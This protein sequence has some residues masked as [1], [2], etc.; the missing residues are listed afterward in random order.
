MSCDLL[1]GRVADYSAKLPAS[2]LSICP[3]ERGPLL[4]QPGRYLDLGFC[5]C[6]N[7]NKALETFNKIISLSKSS[8]L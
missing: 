3:T 8:L 7:V 5:L 2:I 4:S 1:A 6:V